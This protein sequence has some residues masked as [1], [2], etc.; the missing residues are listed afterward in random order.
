M[1]IGF[2][3]AGNMGKAMIKGIISSGVLRP[4]DII[5]SNPSFSSLESLKN[6]GVQVCTDNKITAAAAYVV[7]SVKPQI[8]EKVIKEIAPVIN[9]ETVIITIAPGWTLEKLSKTFNKTTKIIRCMP[10]TPSMVSAGMTALSPNEQ[11][12]ADETAFVVKLFSSFGK[13]EVIPEKLMDVAGA[14]SGS[15]PAFVYMFIEALA[16]GAVAEGMPRKQA[17]QFA[18]QAVMGSAKMVLE[19]DTHPGELKDMVCSPGGTTIEG[20]Q[21][22]QQNS[23]GGSVMQTIRACVAKSKLLS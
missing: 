20:V 4:E 6:E 22:L 2:I 16:D 14:V 1:Q 8:Y 9:P 15:S 12:S 10:N 13:C 17:Y 19:S 18:A 23:F 21:V 11:V 5:A 3:G 7:L